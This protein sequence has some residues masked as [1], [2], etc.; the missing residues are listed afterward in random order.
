MSSYPT[1][2]SAQGG[3]LSMTLLLAIGLLA[4]TLWAVFFEIEQSV[5]AQGQIIPDGRTQVIQSADGGVLEKL[6]VTEGQKVKAGQKLA[7]LEPQR[8]RA[9]FDEGLAKEAALMAALART[10]AEALD[11]APDFGPKLKAY[12]EIVA[13]QRALYLQ[14]K[15][16]LQEELATLQ[17]ALDMSKEELRMNEALLKAGDTSR[18]EVMRAQRQ[19]AEFEGKINA[20]RNKYLQDA[21]AEAT[22]LSEDLA[23]NSFKL[24]E[25]QSVL[26]HTVLRAPVAGVVKYLKVTT[27]GGVLRPGDEMMQISPTDSDM[28]VEVKISPV[29][30]GQLRLGLPVSVKLDAFDYSVY[31]SLSGELVY[32]SSDTLAEQGPNGQTSSYYRAHVRLNPDQTNPMLAKVDLKPGMTS[33]VDV[34]IGTRSVLQYL[35][36]PIFKAFSGAMNE[37]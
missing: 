27:I 5:R 33:T 9:G 35:A 11:Q 25:R 1:P 8:S 29:D 16:G 17:S 10:Q 14:R 6:L 22:K 21:R 34:R 15:R 20:T 36:K 23:A 13:V 19:V 2:R 3:F 24:D 32:L 37:R 12:P 7:E 18:L 31:G 4:F 30:I 28:V 26:G